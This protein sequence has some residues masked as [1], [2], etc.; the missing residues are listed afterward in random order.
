[1]HR[2]SPAALT[3]GLLLVLFLGISGLEISIA[4]DPPSTSSDA[5]ASFAVPDTVTAST[6]QDT[7]L[8]LSLPATIK[9][10]PVTHYEVLRGPALCGVAGQSFTWIPRAA[11]N[12]PYHALLRAVHPNPP[13]DT[14]VVRMDVES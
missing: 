2:N 7:P 13:S 6:P 1:M 11:E 3:S 8:I 10:R 12:P 9:D 4:N 14:L 5:A